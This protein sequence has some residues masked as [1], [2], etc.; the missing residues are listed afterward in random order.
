MSI[1]NCTIPVDR[2]GIPSAEL[3][4]YQPD[5]DTKEVL[6]KNKIYAVEGDTVMNKPRREW[7]DLS[8]LER[9]TCDQMS[10]NTYQPNNGDALVQDQINAWKSRAM[11]PIVRNKVVSV[12]AHATATIMFPAIF[13]QNAQSE[14]QKDAAQVMTDLVDWVAEQSNYARVNLYATISALVNPAAIVHTEYCETY[15]EVKTEKV[16]GK[17]QTEKILDEELSGFKHTVAPVDEIYFPNFYEHDLQKQG[18]IQWRRVQEYAHLKAKYATKYSNFEYVKPGVQVL[19]ND[20]NRSFYDVY[21]SNMRQD[22]CE[23]IITWEK[24][25]D[26]RTIQVN[27]VMLTE[28]DERNPRN[29]HQYPF[30]KFGYELIDEGKCFYYKSLVFKMQQDANIINTIYPMVID[31]TY[32]NMMPPMV[33]VGGEIIGSDVIIPGGVTTFSDVNA[34]LRP[35][36]LAENLGAG[37]NMLKTVEESVTESSATQ[38]FGMGQRQTAYAISKMEQEQATLLGLFVQMRGFFIKDFGK[39]LIGD[40]LQYLTIADVTDITDDPELV[41]KTF[42]LHNKQSD[43]KS[44]TRK[45]MF[46]SSLPDTMPKD[47]KAQEKHKLDQSHKVLEEQG[48]HDSDQEIYKV[49]PKIFREL[50]YSCVVT[51]DVLKPMSEDL[52]RTY[53]L[54]LYD[55]LVQNPEADPEEVLKLILNS[56]PETKKDVNKFIKK[57]APQPPQGPMDML[58]QAISG[59]KGPNP[60]AAQSALGKPGMTQPPQALPTP[61]SK[62]LQN[63]IPSK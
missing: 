43:G 2:Q 62:N 55:R 16:N 3:S 8:T 25:S 21:D 42:L 18:W 48:G 58:N 24:D 35:I 46:D 17:W 34:D 31:G 4:R 47:K 19:Y 56:Y 9:M 28:Y 30:A 61:G 37:L 33:N 32:L 41:Y 40:I 14:S 15:R 63:M 5:E 51:N 13:A 7:N 57:E 6:A 27:N 44:K 29:D 39:L 12:A 1:V 49:H 54:E 52:S 36:K 45:I 11:R 59:G 50:K 10:F 20:A 22:M 38:Q 23:E 53:S 26:T 60:Q